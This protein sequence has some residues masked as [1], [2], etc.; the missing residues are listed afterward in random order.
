M[1]IQNT[2]PMMVCP[3]H[4]KVRE[5]F[6]R[7]DLFL[8]V[9]EQFMTET[10]AMADLVLPAT[11]FLEHDDFYLAGGHTFLQVARKAIEPVGE[12][13]SNHDLLC[14]LARRLGADH[15]GFEM[16]AWEMIEATFKAS[17]LP[18]PATVFERGGHDCAPDFETRH[19]LNGF[20]H[21]DGRFRFKPDWSAIGPGHEPMP[22]LPDHMAVIDEAE[23]ERPFRLVTAPARSFLN[24]TFTETPA[25]RA[26]EGRPTA[27]VHP[28]DC[29][30]LGIAEGDLV[31]ISNGRGSVLVHARPFQGIQPGV[32]VVEGIW[33]NAA[34]VGGIGINALTSADA[35]FPA[36]GAVFHDSAV[37]LA[38]A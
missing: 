35:G 27:L 33:P 25:S 37:A 36:G 26:R 21:P 7:P 10:A 17:G 16:T 28:Q 18:D 31:R 9:H 24:S 6:S 11:T 23:P 19:F 5:G 30:R 4:M 12:A 3:E 20:A 2:N 13:R 22:A 15:P 14:A 38:R 29:A 8:A 34:F 1:L 32:L